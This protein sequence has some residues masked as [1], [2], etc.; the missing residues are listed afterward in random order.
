MVNRLT[1]SNLSPL[2]VTPAK[3]IRLSETEE[4]GHMVAEGLLIGVR[5]VKARTSC[6]D[7]RLT[8]RRGA[9]QLHFDTGL[10][11]EAAGV[12][13]P[14]ASV[15]TCLHTQSRAQELAITAPRRL[16]A[17]QKVKPSTHLGDGGRH[18]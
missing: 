9:R 14:T 7:L 1:T 11:E 4:S 3:P 18:D 6:G 8:L 2:A 17:P 13:T 12:A 10:N 5:R 15:G 16:R